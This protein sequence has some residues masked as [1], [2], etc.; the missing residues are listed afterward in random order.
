MENKKRRILVIDDNEAVRGLLVQMLGAIIEDGHEIHSAESGEKAIDLARQIS[1]DG[2]FTDMQMSGM[3]GLQTFR[4]L[5]RLNP[6]TVVIIMTGGAP[7][8]KIDAALREGAVDC[9]MKPFTI[10]DV[11]AVLEKN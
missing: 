11:R 6:D 8:E 1:F 9:L 2:V 5:K 3:D 10:T 4:E 7:Q